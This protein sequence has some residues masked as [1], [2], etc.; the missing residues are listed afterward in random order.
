[1]FIET[2]GLIGLTLNPNMVTKWAYSL[3]TFT[4]VLQ[5]LENMR[6]TKTKKSWSTT[7]K[8]IV[9]SILILLTVRN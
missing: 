1:M 7:R 3:H 5:D 8:A 4:Q 2:G 6:K 9:E